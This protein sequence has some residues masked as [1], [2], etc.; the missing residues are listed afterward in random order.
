M[1]FHAASIKTS[2]SNH[3]HPS[4]DYNTATLATFQASFKGKFRIENDW[5]VLLDDITKN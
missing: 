3:I 4:G 1:E 5:V 2:C